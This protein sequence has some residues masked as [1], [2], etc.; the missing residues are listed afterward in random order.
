M[1]FYLLSD[2]FNRC[3]GAQEAVGQSL[4]F[5]EQTEKQVFCLYIR[6]TELAGFVTRKEDDPSR[7][8]CISLKHKLGLDSLLGYLAGL[9]GC[10]TYSGGDLRRSLNDFEL[11]SFATKQFRRK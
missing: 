4:I 6:A 2:G 8:F 3:V 10:K 9:I 1:S 7:L 5:P 11:E